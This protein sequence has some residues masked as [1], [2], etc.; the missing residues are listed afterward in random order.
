MSTLPTDKDRSPIAGRIAPAPPA[1]APPAPSAPGAVVQRL[2]GYNNHPVQECRVFR[3]ERRR[4]LPAILNAS[5]ELGGLIPRGLGRAYGDC[6]LNQNGCVSSHV[7]MNR[8]VSFDESTGELEAEGG[9]SFAEIIECLLPRGFFLPVSPGTKF[10]T[11]GGAIA[12]DVHGKNHHRDGSIANF[13]TEI[14]LLT[15][16]GRLLTC[17][18]EH[19]PDAFHATLGGMGLTGMIVSARL[20]LRR[21][22]SAFFRVH[23]ERARDLDDALDRFARTD[24]DHHY[25][26][27]WI[28]CLASGGALGRSVL[29]QGDHCPAADLPES[30]RDRPLQPRL[31]RKHT[32][33]LNFP[34]FAL[35]PLSMRA[36]NSLYYARQ[37]DR[38]SIQPYDSFFY[39]LDAILHWNRLYGRRGYLQHQCVL[40]PERARDGLVELLEALSKSGR[41]SF[42]AVLKRFGP[43]S[44]GML[45]FPREGVTLALD[46]PNR[47]STTLDFVRGLHDVVLKHRGRIYAGKDSCL[48]AAPFAAMYPRLD[49][50][51]RVKQRLDPDGLLTSSLARRLEIVES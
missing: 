30:L 22:E 29:M 28:D 6:A 20:R 38:V 47:G 4:D 19:D 39:P 46:L 23:T 17:S 42:L 40:P 49:E 37:R 43:Q 13:I 51:R 7:R 31:P 11:L 45:S 14:T 50:F 1:P 33:P 16:A 26:V 3:P 32:V 27:A 48:T 44:D 36:F 12:N 18:R 21:V 35:N 24:R 34:S 10:V 15:G 8:F 9:V 41:A 2:A 5:S 25:S